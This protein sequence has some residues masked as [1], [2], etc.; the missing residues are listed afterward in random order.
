MRAQMMSLGE[1]GVPPMFPLSCARARPRTSFKDPA[2]IILVFAHDLEGCESLH[3]VSAIKF[4]TVPRHRRDCSGMR[5]AW[6][7]LR[8]C[9]ACACTCNWSPHSTPPSLFHYQAVNWTAAAPPS[10]LAGWCC[11]CNEANRRI[12]SGALT[13]DWAVHVCLYLRFSGTAVVLLRL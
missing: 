8:W 6:G 7:G 5:H 9:C 13:A 4:T 12:S 3:E 11:K 10:P 1:K 2:H